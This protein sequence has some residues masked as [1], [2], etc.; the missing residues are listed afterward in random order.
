MAVIPVGAAL[1][2]VEPVLV[3]AVRRD[4]GEAEARH[5]IHVGG[6][7]DAVPVDRG[8]LRQAVTHP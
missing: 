8:V 2:D 4:A 3:H 7:Q 5:A 6:Q 1:F